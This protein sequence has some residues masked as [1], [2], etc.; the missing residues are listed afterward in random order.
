[1]NRVTVRP[2]QTLDAI[3]RAIATDEIDAAIMPASYERDLLASNQA[4]LVGWYS[5]LD[6]IPPCS[7]PPR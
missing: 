1:M 5:E 2:V 7:H 6:E 4:K 3:V